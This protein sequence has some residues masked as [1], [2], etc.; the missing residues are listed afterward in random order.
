MKRDELQK[1]SPNCM[2][3]VG[4]TVTTAAAVA[5][6][7]ACAAALYMGRA[8]TPNHPTPLAVPVREWVEVAESAALSGTLPSSPVLL[9]GSPMQQWWE[10][11][12]AMWDVD[13]ISTLASQTS[14][15]DYNVTLKSQDASDACF[16]PHKGAEGLTSPRFVVQTTTLRE[17][18]RTLWADERHAPTEPPDPAPLRRRERHFYLSA[19]AD[20]LPPDLVRPVLEFLPEG[21]VFDER[22]E[23][24]TAGVWREGDEPY[25][26][27]LRSNFWFGA[28]GVCSDTH[29]D[30]SH[31]VFFQASGQK[32]FLLLPPAAHRHLQL[33]PVWHGSHLAARKRLRDDEFVAHGG[34]HATLH[35]GSVLY[36]PPAWFHQVTSLS[37]NAGLNIWTDSL[38][39]DAWRSLGIGNKTK[40]RH[41][42]DWSSL[43]EPAGCLQADLATLF[44][45]ARVTLEHLHEQLLDEHRSLADASESDGRARRSKQAAA[46]LASRYLSHSW[47]ERVPS[48]A[49]AAAR[50]SRASVEHICAAAATT[51]AATVTLISALRAS[52]HSIVSNYAG[53]LNQLEDGSRSLLIDDFTEELV[54]YV[55]GTAANAL[56]SLRDRHPDL[57]HG[58]GAQQLHADARQ[59]GDSTI[60]TFIRH[61]LVDQT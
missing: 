5:A 23:G 28:T 35:P 30:L 10:E 29:F 43:F 50:E 59:L 38:T 37:R 58:P 26:R 48:F 3:S 53:L 15:G 21:C 36:I 18:L 40:L 4:A 16:M 13:A 17:A 32:Q 22:A 41:T 11:H 52:Q 6:L 45:C 2:G 46:L 56:P 39:G 51:D 34:Y 14:A 25:C 44:R 8:D 49:T 47:Q 27:G 1:R 9:R 42:G 61:C 12:G 33:H 54:R 20:D 24:G 7:L 57:G 60:E 55:V 31:N 19:S